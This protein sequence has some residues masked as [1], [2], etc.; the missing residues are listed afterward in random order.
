[1]GYTVLGDDALSDEQLSNMQSSTLQRKRAE[2]TLPIQKILK[3]LHMKN[4]STEN[5]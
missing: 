4:K 5:L 3:L 1:M 2:V